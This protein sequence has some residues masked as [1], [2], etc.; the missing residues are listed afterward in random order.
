[1]IKKL[2]LISVMVIL[3]FLA[4]GQEESLPVPI[5]KTSPQYNE[6]RPLFI[7]G[8]LPDISLGKIINYKDTT[9][10]RSDFGG[11]LLIFDFWNT[12]CSPCV[13]AIVHN[14]SLQRRFS[15]DVQIIMVTKE[16]ASDVKRFITSWENHNQRR[17][18]IPVVVEDEVI[19]SY[20]WQLYHP[21]YSWLL[22]SG[23]FMLQTS[24]IYINEDLIQQILNKNPNTSPK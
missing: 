22:P 2:T 16:Q 18:S 21:N 13:K 23:K 5:F 11:K 9:A 12:H 20:F 19:K 8:N 6:G 14:D 4:K 1:M 17:L 3:C 15:K 10:W 24:K 7:Q